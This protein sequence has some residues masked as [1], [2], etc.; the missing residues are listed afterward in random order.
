[1]AVILSEG[2][3]GYLHW[4][5]LKKGQSITLA[6]KQCYFFMPSLSR[7]PSL[8]SLEL[9]NAVAISIGTTIQAPKAAGKA[10]RKKLPT[11]LLKTKDD[12]KIEFR[13]SLTSTQ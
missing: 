13:I 6:F 1:M 10:A 5:L 8:E 4:T 2:L 9:I 3:A 12:S 7:L 11:D